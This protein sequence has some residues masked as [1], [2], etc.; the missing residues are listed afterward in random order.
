[1]QFPAAVCQLSTTTWVGT[2]A[3]RTTD[4]TIFPTADRRGVQS[5]RGAW[6][7]PFGLSW[8]DPIGRGGLPDYG[9]PNVI[10]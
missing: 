10:G 9:P 2:D 4:P 3:T 7:A 5:G 6:L 8:I 1:M